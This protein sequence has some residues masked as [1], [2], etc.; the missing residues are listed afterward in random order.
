MI[1]YNKIWLRNLDIQK[2]LQKSLNHDDIS[3][4]EFNAIKEKYP[5]EFYTPNLFIRVGMFLLT[6]IIVSFSFALLLLMEADF[7]IGFLVFTGLICYVILEIMIRHK[8]HFNSGVDDA[9]MWIS[10]G[11]ITAA[12]V[13][14]LD[15][16][17]HYKTVNYELVTAA[18]LFL[19]G[20]FFSLR[21]ADLLM[22]A[23][24]F[25]CFIAF[26]FFGWL[27]VGFYSLA[28][29]PFLIMLFSG[30]IYF[31][32]V[33]TR[34]KRAAV[35]Y[36][37]C[38]AVLQFTSLLTLYAAGN[39]FVVRELG[40]ELST[41]KPAINGDIPLNW[42]FWIWTCIVPFVYIWFGI[43]NKSVILLRTGL[44]LITAAAFTFRNYHHILPVESA[45][46]LAGG[47]LLAAAFGI[48]KY[49]KTPKY[50][51]TH[52]DQED[53]ALLDKIQVESLIVSETFQ[54]QPA[55][56]GRMGGGNFGGGGAS[57]DF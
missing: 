5:Q 12:W 8:H 47:L 37:N 25:F 23:V 46:C 2:Q 33:S 1:I 19:L 14:F 57:G 41:N 9:L 35:W 17:T 52:K 13:L 28:T 6:Q 40:S 20:T 15:R 38:L 34:A 43:K 48:T 21:F 42:F 55:E 7:N 49:L 32:S 11:F 29:M 4:A 31:A 45:L 10:A 56:A 39:Y 54:S 3:N 18:F 26:V 51:F 44:V 22:T 53:G 50:G 36:L 27:Q 24:T 16:F 30:I